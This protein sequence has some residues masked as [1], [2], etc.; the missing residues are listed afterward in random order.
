MPESTPIICFGQQP[1]GLFPKRFLYAKFQTARRL[2]SEIGGQIVFFYHDS[3]HDPRETRTILRHKKSGDPFEINFTYANKLQRKYS[4][5]YLKRVLPDWHAKTALQLPAYA[6][7][8][9][10]DVFRAIPL[11]NVADFCLAMYRHMGLL[12][13]ITVARSSD[14][15]V[16]Q[17]ACAVPDFFVDVPHESETVRARRDP[18]TGQLQLHEGG[19]SYLTLPSQPF[20]KSQISPARDTRLRWMQSVIKCTHYVSG[21]GEQQYLNRSDA[22]EITYVTRDEIDDIDEA[23]VPPAPPV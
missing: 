15:S 8:H 19:P 3:D 11:T 23:Y 4:P 20:T 5:L 13:G 6:D 7:K 21:A 2:Q 12:D 16:R 10:A 14:P 22:P 1:C 9:W 17:A 18:A